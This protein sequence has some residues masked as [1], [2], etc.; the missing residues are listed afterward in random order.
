MSCIRTRHGSIGL[1]LAL[2]IFATLG[3]CKSSTPIPPQSP[4]STR[5]AG[6]APRPASARAK[7]GEFGLDLTAGDAS[8]AAGDNFYLYASATWI[9]T[10]PIPADRVRWGTFDILRTTAEEDVRSIIQELSAKDA[11][12]GTI[13]RKIGDYYRAYM[14]EAAIEA[15]GL[16]PVQT[17]LSRIAGA[18]DHIE[19]IRIASEPGFDTRVPIAAFI[20]L[21]QKNPERYVV[22]VSHAGLGLPEREYY[23]NTEPKFEEIRSKYRAHIQKLLTLAGQTDAG[24]K[25]GR[26]VALETEIAKLHWKIADRRDRDK[27]YNRRTRPETLTLLTGFP[28]QAMLEAQGLGARGELVLRELDALP[29]LAA[30]YKST[31]LSTWKEYMTFACLSSHAD[32]LPKAL[33]DEDFDFFGRTLNGQPEQRDRWKRAV[34]AVNDALGEAVGEVYVQRHFSPDAKAKMQALVENLRRAYGQRIDALAW[35]TPQTKTVA[36]EKLA[37]FRVK[38]G[39]P[40]KWRDYR[41]LEVRADDPIGNVHRAEIFDYQRRLARIDKPTDRDE[42]NM[43]PQTVNAY[44]NSVFNEIVFPA[45]ILQP[46]FFDP[47]ADAAVNYGGIGGVIGHE[48]GHGFDDQGSKSDARG[49]LRDW[50]TPADVSAFKGLTDRLATQYD[51]F[52]ALPGLN[53]NGRLTLGENIGDNGGLSVSLAAYKLSLGNQPAPVLANLTGDQRFFLSWA[54]VWRTQAREQALRN[55]VLTDSHSPP[56]F[57]VNGTVRNMSAWYE[58]FDVKPGQKLYLPAHERV[59]IW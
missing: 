43:T 2:L 35:M 36:R 5:Q 21:D 44:Y 28:L 50:W 1:T 34:V 13:Q 25:A 30:L 22:S 18:R 56:E 59:T 16:A 33:A 41:S 15:A 38:I 47:N 14:N 11:A 31:P 39:Y 10:T 23:L 7:I 40:D 17:D 26:I 57:R 27:T 24:A 52:Q 8:I 19:L 37:A 3:A 49:V 53:V 46:P 4:T 29:K 51:G 42:W 48:M 6:D 20:S 54:Q 32:L 12:Q 45:A 58:A 9:K 55:Q